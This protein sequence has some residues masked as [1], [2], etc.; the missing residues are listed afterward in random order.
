MFKYYSEK[1]DVVSKKGNYICLVP[2][3]EALFWL[4]NTFFL[5]KISNYIFKLKYLEQA[6]YS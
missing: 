1:W 4:Q 5:C 2:G 3:K 6:V